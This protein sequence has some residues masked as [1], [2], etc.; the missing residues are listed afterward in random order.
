MNY[1][2]KTLKLFNKD[3]LIRLCINNA[4]TILTLTRHSNILGAV[5]EWDGI[6]NNTGI[7]DTSGVHSRNYPDLCDMMD[8]L[9][10]V[11]LFEEADNTD[12]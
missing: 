3:E 11:A 5:M 9:R 8:K 1:T 2:K 4:E 6:I 12:E 10:K 7:D